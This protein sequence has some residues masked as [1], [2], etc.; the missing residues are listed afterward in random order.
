MSVEF[1]CPDLGEGLVEAKV[2]QW[3]VQEGSYIRKE[4]IIALIETDKSVIELPAVDNCQIKTLSVLEN[5]K[6]QVGEPLYIYIPERSSAVDKDCNGFILRDSLSSVFSCTISNIADSQKYVCS[7]FDE[8]IINKSM[9]FDITALISLA[10]KHASTDIPQL[11]ASII[12]NDENIQLIANPEVNIGLI[13]QIGSDID[14]PVIN[15]S[16]DKKL[17]DI[18]Q[19]IDSHKL[20]ILENKKPLNSL[21]KSICISNIGHYGGKHATAFVIPPTVATVVIGRVSNISDCTVIPL[22]LCFDHRLIFGTEAA[23]FISKMQEYIKF[24]LHDE[25][26]A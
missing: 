25:I 19:D 22:S 4:E 21:K 1:I 10:V 26:L 16:N 15:I 6:V 17:Y 9:K 2:I 13:M 11:N 7:I 18:R 3:N 23:S 14:I 8:I 12:Q 24:Y 20:R 5:Q